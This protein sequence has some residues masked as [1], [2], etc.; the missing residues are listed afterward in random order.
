MTDISIISPSLN[1][2]DYIADCIRSVAEQGYAVEHL[3]IDGQSSDGTT[4]IIRA[5]GADVQIIKEPAAG[6]YAAVNTGILA[7]SGDIIGIL[8][9][10]DFYASPGVLE[11]VAS[12]FQ[13]SSVDACYGDL[14]YVDASEPARVVRFWRAGDYQTRRFL[15]GW[16]PPH[17]TFFL[18]RK[19]YEQFGLYR[20]DLGTAADYELMVR[21]LVRHGVN[22]T[23]V[24]QVLVHMRTG[25]SSNASWRARIAANRMD[26]RAWQVNGLN[27]YPWT[28]LAKPLRKVGQ[29]WS[30]P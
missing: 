9:A 13:D 15:H 21:V 17:P 27:P 26:R 10:D 30:R 6:I 19:I 11:R 8:H 22:A 24:P 23:Y 3:V 20:N 29:W 14:C 12:V 7:S 1:S 5:S 25:G 28:T 2:V 4:D 18:R 16:M